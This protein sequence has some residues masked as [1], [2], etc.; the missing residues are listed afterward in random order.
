M[1]ETYVAY[2]SCEKLVK[3]SARQAA[4]SIPQASDKGVAFPKTKDGE[5]LGTGEG[6]WYQCEDALLGANGSS[7]RLTSCSIGPYADLQYLG[8]DH[9]FTHVS[10]DRPHAV[11]S[12]RTRPNM[13]PT[14]PRSILLHS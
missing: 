10:T 9:V 13:A 14:S 7:D 1:T 11:F 12:C 2:G 6:W 8:P 3:E 5:D 4:Y